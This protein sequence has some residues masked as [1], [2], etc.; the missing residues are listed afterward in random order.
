VDESLLSLVPEAILNSLYDAVYVTDAERRIIFWNRAAEQLTGFRADEV[1]GHCCGENIL[2]HVNDNGESLCTGDC[3]LS[4]VLRTGQPCET[5]MFLHHKDGP[6]IPVRVRCAPLRDASGRIRGAVEIFNDLSSLAAMQDRLHALERLAY[7]DSLTQIPNRRRI[8]EDLQRRLDER[9]RYGWACGVLLVDIDQFKKVND[10][11]GH[12]AGDKVLAMVA[13]TLA[14]NLR[15]FDAVGRWGGEEFLLVLPQVNR[16]VM[17]QI[18]ERLRV[19]VE[20]SY[21]TL[22]A[23]R[24][25]V[26]VSVGG[27]LARKGDNIE[28]LVKRADAQLYRSKAAGCNRVSLAEEGDDE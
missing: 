4:G 19:L 1:K 11:S 15:S 5:A 18:A 22:G 26:T 6:R 23:L 12:A 25:A 28:E 27:A 21:L 10:T 24:L 16:E 8:E 3:P 13:S 7:V 17:G 2:Q 14:S 20:K 9:S